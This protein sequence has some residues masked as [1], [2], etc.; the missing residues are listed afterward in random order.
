VLCLSPRLDPGAHVS[1]WRVPYRTAPQRFELKRLLVPRRDATWFETCARSLA[2]ALVGAIM[3]LAGFGTAYRDGTPT[4]LAERIAITAL[5]VAWVAYFT[6]RAHRAYRTNHRWDEAAT[7][8]GAPEAVVELPENEPISEV[9]TERARIAA[10]SPRT[11][12]ADADADENDQA[13]AD[14]APPQEQSAVTG[15]RSALRSPR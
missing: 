13:S 9:P 6:Y 10:G 14:V 4:N 3:L 7:L 12:I 5:L 11:R 8:A 2:A 1:Y 15:Q